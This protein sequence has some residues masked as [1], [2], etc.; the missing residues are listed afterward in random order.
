[1]DE[2]SSESNIVR[3]YL[4]WVACLPYG[5]LFIIFLNLND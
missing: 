5:V 4:E 2:M 1:M 3:S